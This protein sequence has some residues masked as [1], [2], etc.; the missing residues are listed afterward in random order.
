[1]VRWTLLIMGA[2]ALFAA[3]LSGCSRLHAEAK[4]SSE[5]YEESITEF[6]PI[7]KA[8]PGDYRARN[9]LGFCYL[10]AGRFEE[11][12]EQFEAVQELKPGEPYSVLY[13]G[14]SYL[15]ND[16]L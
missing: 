6:E 7:V 5:N 15:N 4:F 14:M 2:L 16:Q 12:I 13:L 3:S 1:M 10:K 9:T 11:A 8:H